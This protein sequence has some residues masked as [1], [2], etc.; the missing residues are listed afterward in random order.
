[1]LIAL[2]LFHEREQVA[3]A[4]QR[5][6]HDRSSDNNTIITDG[7]DGFHYLLL[8]TRRLGGQA[9]RQA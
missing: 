6:Q 8:V 7:Q 3:N 5:Q 9:G 2:H 1:M 4:K